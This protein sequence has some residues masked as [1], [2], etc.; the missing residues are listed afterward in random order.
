MRSQFLGSLVLLFCLSAG[1][2]DM[3]MDMSKADR[4]KAASAHEKMA[5]CLRSD[6]TMEACHEEMRA[7][8]PKMEGMGMM[9]KGGKMKHNCH[10]DEGSE[11]SE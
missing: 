2:A 5:A 9:K 7:N 1:A 10:E 11:D 4:E 3:K 8:H 6:K